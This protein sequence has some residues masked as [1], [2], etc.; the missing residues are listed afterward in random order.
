M[1]LRP[2]SLPPQLLGLATAVPPHVLD[3]SRASEFIGSIYGQRIAGYGALARVFASTGIERRYLAE[4]LEWFAQERGFTERSESYLRASCDIFREVVADALANAGLAAAAIDD[5]VMVSSTGIATPSIDARVL[6]EMGFRDDVHRLPVFGLGCAAGV[7]GLAIASRIARSRPGATVLLVTIELCSLA[8]RPDRATKKDLV[9]TALFGDGA[10]AAI[11]RCGDDPGLV[12]L[13]GATEHLWA[14][15]LDMM[16][17][18]TDEVGLGVILS[19]SLPAFITREF[20]SE[21]DRA[22]AR[23]D[24]DPASIER[25]VCH[26]GA[27]RVLEAIESSMDLPAGALDSERSVMRDYGN[28]S[29]PTVL[30]VLERTIAE[31]FHGRAMLAAMGPG[32]TATFVEADVPRGSRGMAAA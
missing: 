30:F 28:M 9:S 12:S 14:N 17:W 7:T 25:V 11:L 13:G 23:I 27:T 31:G 10:A 16:G 32:F 2:S 29:S 26:P 20:R 21:Y 22:M 18:S 8:F 24:V 1:N 15:T 4:P 6:P 5:V 19:R 3:Q